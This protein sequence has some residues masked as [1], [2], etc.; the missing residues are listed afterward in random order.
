[1]REPQGR[2]VT[3]RLVDAHADS[4]PEASLCRYSADL[5]RRRRT[6]SSTTPS[7]S[8]R[9]PARRPCA[10]GLPGSR[11]TGWSIWAA[12]KA[13]CGPSGGPGVGP[14]AGHGAELRLG[15][16]LTVTCGCQEASAGL[17]CS[18][19]VA[20]LLAYAARQHLDSA[21][22]LSA[23]DGAIE[24]RVQRGRT[25]VKVQPLGG[26]PYFGTWR[27]ASITSSTHFPQSYRV[28]L[29]SLH[30]RANYCTCPDFA[31]NR[32]GP[33]STSRRCCT[34]C[35][36]AATTR[37]TGT[38]RH[39]TRTSTSRGRRG[40]A[41]RAPAPQPHGRP[42]PRS[43]PDAYFDAEAASA[44]ACPTTSSALPTRSPSVATST[45]GR[46]PRAR[47]PARR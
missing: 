40:P 4:Q 34:G 29:R 10:A 22:L 47:P 13:C 37:T 2:S 8:R 23:A 28:H 30:R 44:A 45:W 38:G 9:W 42:R 25:E 6:R 17:A 36:S 7:S 5:P 41:R 12:R 39:P 15:R 27:A 31:T 35:A 3:F 19:A 33:A 21:G 20:A 32:L 18:H 11:R 43:D 16:N 26:T 1:M 14:P 46:T 24:E